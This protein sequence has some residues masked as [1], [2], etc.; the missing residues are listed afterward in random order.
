M[1]PICPQPLA[2]L[3]LC[4]HI[5]SGPAFTLSL[6]SNKI[7]DVVA[8]NNIN[9]SVGTE[10]GHIMKL[11]NREPES[12]AVELL[13][14][15]S[16]MGQSTSG[17]GITCLVF[18]VFLFALSLP[19]VWFNERRS[20]RAD[21]LVSRGLEECLS[22]SADKL[23]LQNRGRLVHVQGMVEGVTDLTDAQFQDVTV[24]GC[25]RLQSTL[26]A[27]EWHQTTK[28]PRLTEDRRGGTS[29]FHTEWTTI[30]R[31]STRFKKPSPENPRVPGNLHLGT[32]T[33]V[34]PNVRMGSFRVPDD[35]VSQLRKFEP[36][37]SKLP[38]EI[39]S[40][41]IHF[42]ANVHD[43][44][45][46]ARPHSSYK[47]SLEAIVSD[48]QVGDLRARFMLV[49]A[50]EATV[51]AVQ[52]RKGDLET[53]IPYRPTMKTCF[54]SEIDARQTLIEEGSKPLRE[55]K[56]DVA[57]CTSGG[58][59]ATCCCCPCNL[60][61]H[62]CKEEV[63]TEEIYFISPSHVAADVPFRSVVPRSRYRASI[64]RVTSW[65]VMFA[66]AT[67]VVHPYR[68]NLITNGTF[69][70]FGKDAGIVLAA[71]VTVI[72][73]GLIAAASY[74]CYNFI[75]AIEWLFVTVIVFMFPFAWGRL[76]APA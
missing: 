76:R 48:H 37:M 49:A 65:I 7:G 30:H 35:L 22:V 32:F 15:A 10:M 61:A 24:P 47:T 53:F 27:F 57:C 75:L 60:I 62:F 73:S 28:V 13:E 19:M 46:Y 5:P 52:C 38:S 42:M 74:S 72:T 23:I 17:G 67:L 34:C 21:T 71:M 68:T 3:V 16:V 70:T 6:Q 36:A 18:G 12:L 45:Y 58:C 2:I 29:S 43:G 4:L 1:S 56:E 69:G 25:L 9:V 39:I 14:A 44:Y 11:H 63:I 8:R 50:C 41:G 59:I 33:Q 66:G 64:F 20:V 31:D 55:L 40:G 51:V 54:T 26:E